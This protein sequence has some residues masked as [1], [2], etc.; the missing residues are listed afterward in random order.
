MSMVPAV[1]GTSLS[2]L[3]YLASEP[4]L[5]PNDPRLKYA[6]ITLYIARVPGSKGRQDSQYLESFFAF[7]FNTNTTTSH[8]V[9][10]D[11]IVPIVFNFGEKTAID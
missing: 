8:I 2:S 9:L 6:S 3:T 4:P 5:N 7:S 10:I 11:T 1:Q